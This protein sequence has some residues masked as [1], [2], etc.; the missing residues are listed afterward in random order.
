MTVQELE[1]ARARLLALREQVAGAVSARLHGH[2]L[3]RHDNAALPRRA[4]DT[5]DEAAAETARAADISHLSRNA[6]ALAEIEAA[7]ERIADGSYGQCSDCG[8]PIASA[9]L[10]AQPAAPRCTACQAAHEKKA[11]QARGA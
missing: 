6:D 2:G 1:Q 10:L 11:A 5:D 8:E 4:E 3:E 7:L 9:R